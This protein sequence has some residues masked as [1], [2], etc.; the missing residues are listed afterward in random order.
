MCYNEIK[1]KVSLECKH[2]L[3]IACFLEMSV[4]SERQ[5]IPFKCHM[6]RRKYNWKKEPFKSSEVIS[7]DTLEERLELLMREDNENQFLP[8][9]GI[10]SK[11]FEVIIRI[12]NNSFVFNPRQN[13]IQFI[14]VLKTQIDT[15]TLKFLISEFIANNFIQEDIIRSLQGP[16]FSHFRNIDSHLESFYDNLVIKK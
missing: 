5:I 9:V 2:E 14:V 13:I 16:S 3:C 6:C 1:D 11:A 7:E 4:S 15:E 12:N 10:N 8:L